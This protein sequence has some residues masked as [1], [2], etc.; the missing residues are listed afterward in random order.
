MRPE[1]IQKM[2]KK[3]NNGKASSRKRVNFLLVAPHDSIVS[4]VGSFNNWDH[5]RHPMKAK[6][7]SGSFRASIK[8]PSGHHEYKFFVSGA[9]VYDRHCTE[10][11][12]N[13]DGTLSSIIH[14]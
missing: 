13:P 14:V 12:V 1:K 9:W 5:R 3:I 10:Y 2:P 7:N 4:V 11:V 8:L 6:P